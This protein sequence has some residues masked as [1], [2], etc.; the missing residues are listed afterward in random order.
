MATAPRP[1]QKYPSFNALAVFSESGKKETITTSSGFMYGA[2][3]ES[4]VALNVLAFPYEEVGKR[5]KPRQNSK[6]IRRQVRQFANNLDSN[7]ANIAAI[8]DFDSD[9]FSSS[10]NLNLETGDV[11]ITAENVTILGPAN[12]DTYTGVWYEDRLI[13]VRANASITQVLAAEGLGND[14]I[15][16]IC[17][18]YTS[19][20]PRD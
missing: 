13:E 5:F 4:E 18:L 6:D 12:Y 20:S 14:E 19:P 2:D 15:Y 8:S 7:T 11:T 1:S 16:E 17:L 10:A 3:V 9:R